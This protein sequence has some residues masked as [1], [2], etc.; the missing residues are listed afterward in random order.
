MRTN[1]CLWCNESVYQNRTNLDIF[2]SNDLLCAKCRQLIQPQY[3]HFNQNG[4]KGLAIYSY[5]ATLAEMFFQFKQGLDIDL[6][7]VFLPNDLSR[8]QRYIG[9]RQC[10]IAPSSDASFQKRHFIPL[11]L[12]CNALHRKI[13][14]PFIKFSDEQ[15][16]LSVSKRKDIQIGLKDSIRLR[17]KLCLI[18]D[19]FVSGSTIKACLNALTDAGYSDIK[20]LIIAL[21]KDRYAK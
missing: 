13:E 14:S 1:H 17:K 20:V 15:K 12:I 3:I 2:F 11:K 7:S 6:A 10:I 18:D 8:I 9:L 4:V 5:D 21:D 16:S 19:V